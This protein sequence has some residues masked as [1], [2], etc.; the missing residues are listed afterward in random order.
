MNKNRG[1]AWVSIGLVVAVA[2]SESPASGP[3]ATDGGGTGGDDGGTGATPATSGGAPGTGGRPGS[4]GANDA[5]TSGGTTA[6]GGATDAGADAEG[7]VAAGGCTLSSTLTWSKRANLLKPRTEL[8]AT[9]FGGHIFAFGGYDGTYAVADNDEYDPVADKWTSRKGMPTARLRPVVAVVGN[10]IYVV[11]GA[12]N[13]D[14]YAAVQANEVY[15]PSTDTWATLAPVPSLATIN[16]W[17]GSP[18]K[19]LYAD[20]DLGGA[21]LGDKIY[22]ATSEY[23]QVGPTLVYDTK[24][25]SWSPTDQ[26]I[27]G[28]GRPVGAEIGGSVFFI[29]EPIGAQG[30][31]NRTA[32]F[33]PL[34]SPPWT[35]H[36]G[37]PV[38]RSE[39]AVAASASLLFVIGGYEMG[40][41]YPDSAA[42]D[43]YD[44]K[45]DAW[46]TMPS[47]P[48]ARR[49]GAAAFVDD[50]L[51]FMGGNT[52]GAAVPS[53]AVEAGFCAVANGPDSGTGGTGGASGSGG[54]GGSTSSPP[55][56]PC[57][58]TSALTWRTR[59][60]LPHPRWELGASVVGGRIYAIGGNRGT[61]VSDNDMYDPALDRWMAKRPMSNRRQRPVVT[62]VGG[63]IYVLTGYDL[64]SPIPGV[65]SPANEV[66]DPA[67][68]TWTD[69]AP[70]PLPNTRAVPNWFM[71]GAALG[72]KIY[73][74]QSELGI[75]D[76]T[77][78]YDTKADA[79]S[80]MASTPL[81]P[82]QPAAAAVADK[83]F[84]VTEPVFGEGW[85]DRVASFDPSL[86][87]PWMVV[88]D[89]P[90]KNTDQ[91]VASSSSLFFVLGGYST[92]DPYPD[93]ASVDAYDPATNSWKTYTSATIP[94]VGAAAAV[95]GDRLYFIG[96]GMRGLGGRQPLPTAVVEEGTCGL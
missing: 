4:G 72:D 22:M 89:V 17:T 7:S 90:T 84:F 10:K 23:G 88:S 33:D 56:S 46:V 39:Q 6:S 2:C 26:V 77:L 79:W 24:N 69:L 52:K 70:V 82:G 18:Y 54:G 19:Q 35:I 73:I 3:T 91:A 95:A 47:A 8:R 21:V 96:G 58:T 92:V 85:D 63:K 12:A 68:D 15:D 29:T 49:S 48:I 87:L 81:R 55:A 36:A 27:I 34:A 41:Q 74:V 62:V 16:G 53:V 1:L 40:D 5:A 20:P 25:D 57:T 75:V 65:F 28:P 38:R 60:S 83:L 9:V 78:V 76:A 31:D 93:S 61:A 59:A 51:Y 86:S 14:V 30:S 45:A 50:H 43:A 32:Q 94:R 66:Y 44:P 80:P 67:T 11:G 64:S 42:V 71:G 13:T 37:P